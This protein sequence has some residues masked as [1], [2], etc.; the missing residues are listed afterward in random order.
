MTDII[1]VNT[2]GI[3]AFAVIYERYDYSATTSGQYPQQ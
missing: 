3:P 1:N 2:S